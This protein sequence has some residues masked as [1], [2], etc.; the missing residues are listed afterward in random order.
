MIPSRINVSSR[1]DFLREGLFGFSAAATVPLFLGK[2]IHAA[3]RAAQPDDDRILVVVQLS[4]GNDGLSTVV[5]YSDPAYGRA[6]RQTHI[7]EEQVLRINDRVGLHPALGHLKKLYEDGH[8]SVIQGVSYPN[9]NRSHFESM[10]VWHSGSTE[11]ARTG[12]GW[13][14]RAVD[15]ACKNRENPLLSINVGNNSPLALF[16]NHHR[17]ISIPKNGR[18]TLGRRRKA[19][20]RDSGTTNAGP[21]A[22]RELDFLVRVAANAESSFKTIRTAVQDYRPRVDFPRNPLANDLRTVAAMIDAGLPTRVYYVA[23]GGFDTHA[24]QRGR[25]D[26]LMRQLS[27]ALGAFVN[28][29]ETRKLLDRVLVLTFTEFGRRVQENASQGT[30]HGVAGPVFLMGNKIRP[31]IHGDHPSLTELVGG[32]LTMNV[33]FRRV[34]ASVLEDWIGTPAAPILGE[35]YESLPL[36][37]SKRIARF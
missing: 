3:S 4:G 24:N 13:I 2:S 10:D 27:N 29:L 19:S 21:S 9:P 11:G 22:L 36:I 30:D 1:R 35:G 14:G 20:T 37:G 33:D 23:L 16:G 32:D 12:T 25:H 28:E 7:P 26:N 31:G 18:P 15:S 6:R 17:P 5:P 34:Y 8:L